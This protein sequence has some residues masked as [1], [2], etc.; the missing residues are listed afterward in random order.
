MDWFIVIFIVIAALT[1]IGSIIWYLFITF[2]A[3][4]TMRIA[5]KSLDQLFPKLEHELKEIPNMPVDLQNARHA[6]IFNEIMQARNQMAQLDHRSRQRYESKLYDLMNMASNMGIDI[7][8]DLGDPTSNTFTRST[9]NL[10]LS[11]EV[12]K[13]DAMRNL[14]RLWGAKANKTS[15][16]LAQLVDCSLF[17][18]A[19]TIS[20]SRILI[21]AF[22]HVPAKLEEVRAL[23]QEHDEAASRRGFTTLETRIDLGST[24][25]FDLS[26]TNA[27]VEDSPQH[28]RW[29]G[30]T[31]YVSFIARIADDAQG[32]LTGRLVVSQDGIPIGRI[33]FQIIT[34]QRVEFAPPVNEPTGEAVRF[35]Q[36]FI[37]YASKDR[38]E[39]LKRTQMLDKLGIAYFQDLLNLDSGD[40]W[41]QEIYRH[42]DSADLFLL[43]WS[44][45]ARSS[46]WVRKELDYAMAIKRGD[47]LAAPQIMPV[48]IE[49]PPPPPPPEEL[50][51]LHFN[52]RVIYYM[53][54]PESKEVG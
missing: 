8:T 34:T 21:Q 16:S 40:R 35:N 41:A 18:P 52:D 45:A 42:I 10:E 53:A 7:Q 28:L 15:G 9:R 24:L 38:T 33:L 51:H 44:S 36:A 26:L 39:V 2:V 54:P 20:G 37:S 13:P 14:D 46:Q 5:Y 1:F 17:A 48:I 30:R 11:E 43:F 29:A 19:H 6:Q 3:V 47:E 49:G 12:P 4:R 32:L 27:T 22:A 23:A 50:K 25:T 31:D